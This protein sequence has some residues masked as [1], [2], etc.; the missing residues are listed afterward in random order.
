MLSTV[1]RL[2]QH[3]QAVVKLSRIFASTTSRNMFTICRVVLE[4]CSSAR[5]A[6][7]GADV[8]FVSGLC[9]DVLQVQPASRGAKSAAAAS[10]WTRVSQDGVLQGDGRL[11]C[12]TYV[13][14]CSGTSRKRSRNSKAVHLHVFWTKCWLVLVLAATQQPIDQL[15]SEI[16]LRF[17]GS[18]P[19]GAMATLVYR[20]SC[21]PP[22]PTCKWSGSLA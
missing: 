10:K 9:R 22:H 4:S 21:P 16:H 5:C 18:T 1:V 7:A 13:H 14:D 20:P 15:N 12:S 19:A 11:P 6:P 17:C 3:R 2:C 8:P